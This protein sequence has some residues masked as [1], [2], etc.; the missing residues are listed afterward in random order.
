MLT[1]ATASTNRRSSSRIE[2]LTEKAAT[3][4]AQRLHQKE[5]ELKERMRQKFDV[6]IKIL[7]VW[8]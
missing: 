5:L 4:K 6:G 8:I 2:V 3:E 1:A 7:K